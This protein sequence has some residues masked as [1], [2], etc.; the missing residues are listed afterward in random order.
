MVCV[1][2]KKLKFRVGASFF[3]LT[4]LM[5]I[6]K[7]GYFFGMYI[8]AVVLHEF[9]HEHTAR[10]L[11][12]RT[13]EIF[14]SA[15]GAVLYGDFEGVELNDE[16][17]IALS[18]P[19]VNLALA[20]LTLASWW[21]YPPCYAFTQPFYLANMCIFAI[22]LLPCYPLDGGRVL[23]S[24]LN[25]KYGLTKAKKVFMYVGI[26]FS[27]LFF[28]LFVSVSLFVGVNLTFG[29]F[30]LF[31]FLGATDMSKQNVCQKAVG[32]NLNAKR[33]QKGMEVKTFALSA[34]AAVSSLLKIKNSHYL[35]NVEIVDKNA[36]LLGAFGYEDIDRILL[37]Y[38][39]D[40]KLKDID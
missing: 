2:N 11:G 40:A 38:P 8:L 23:F 25:K 33:L 20:V 29:L 31:L 14:L 35:A 24:L 19:L 9:A 6:A 37:N 5:L 17:K 3:A 1:K 16:A 22:N 7:N 18:G 36:R 13:S 39:M 15:F 30:G 21:V 34:D 12:Y 4:F 32:L 10:K 28:A 26:S 27:V